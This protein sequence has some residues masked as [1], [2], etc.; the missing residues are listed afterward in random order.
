MITWF[1][2]LFRTKRELTIAE[3]NFA[4]SLQVYEKKMV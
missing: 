2:S 4:R 3:V 1:I